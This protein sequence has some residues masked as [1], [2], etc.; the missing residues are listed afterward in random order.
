LRGPV[1]R[2]GSPVASV[3][4]K[5][6]VRNPQS[7]GD[8]MII[9]MPL[10]GTV[11]NVSY[12]VIP[13]KT[14]P[15]GLTVLTVEDAKLPRVT[16]KLA[17]PSGRVCSP[18]E[19]LSL[20]E[21]G[22]SLLNEGTENLS[23][24]QISEKLDYWAIQ[25]ESEAH[26]EHSMLSATALSDYLGE[27]LQLLSDFVLCPSFPEEEIEK[28]RTRWR[29]SLMAQRTQPDFLANERIFHELYAGHPY[30]KVSIPLAH[31]E[32]A[33]RADL[34]SMFRSFGSPTGAWLLFAGPVSQQEA[35]TLTDRYFGGWQASS[36]PKVTY[37]PVRDLASPLICL[38]HRPH[39]VQSKVLASVRTAPR[40]DPEEIPLR[41]ANQVLGGSASARLFMNLREDKGY[42]YG[43]YSRLRS[44]R[45]DGLIMAGASVRADATIASL[46]EIL[47]E[48]DRMRESFPEQAEM[49]RARSEVIG[50]FIRQM[51][52][53]ASIGSLELS[54]RI[55]ELPDDYYENF[56]PALRQTTREE[57]A[58]VSSRFFDRNRML[59]TVVADRQAVEKGL[60][61]MGEVVVSDTEGNRI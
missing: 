53:P 39:S 38:I 11:K 61:E 56:I 36:P 54:R 6:A 47:S 50:S 58:K 40:K 48:F 9:K 30:R 55:M 57:V 37:P 8:A 51:E 2:F 49:E 10:P 18:D 22:L 23:S 4:P 1:I 12:P 25:Y 5:S 43:A 14:L 3:N 20:M 34:V 32:A 26:M 15:N 59:V 46:K 21:M 44:Y 42:T 24:R 19:N 16:V 7:K 29:S 17:F 33:Q 28:L 45:E 60:R 27:T 13:A 35:L 52:M 41:L 31:L